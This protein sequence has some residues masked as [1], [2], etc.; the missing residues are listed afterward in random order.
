MKVHKLIYVYL[1]F[2]SIEHMLKTINLILHE[3]VHTQILLTKLYA[4]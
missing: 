3:F 1:L 4:K 2:K